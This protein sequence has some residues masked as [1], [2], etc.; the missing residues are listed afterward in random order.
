MS[1]SKSII[2]SKNSAVT[3]AELLTKEGITSIAP[4]AGLVYEIVKL[5]INHGKNYI[6]DRTEDRVDEFHQA[7]LRGKIS[8]EETQEFVQKE[9]N[10]DDYYAVLSACVQDIENEKVLIYSQLMSSLIETTLDSDVR[11]HFIKSCK[12]LSYSELC[13]L[14]D[15]YINS[16][17]DMMTVGGTHQQVKTMLTSA[18]PLRDL[19]IEKLITWG[20][21]DKEN[22]KITSL[23]E[24]LVSAI[25]LPETLHPEAIGRK[26]FSGIRVV[27]V[28]Y[29]LGDDMHSM[30]AKEIQNALWGN[31]IKSSIHVLDG[32]QSRSGYFYEAAVLIADGKKLEPKYIEALSQFAKNKPIFRINTERKSEGNEIGSIKFTAELT[33]SSMESL[34]I[35]KEVSRFISNII[36]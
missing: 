22:V 36:A 10:P 19:A 31:Q 20:Y 8:E 32:H 12:E 26:P 3:I 1:Q 5:M 29:Q 14:K 9:F 13:F 4:G 16:K 21:F 30:V 6:T 24:K 2:R 7:L 35:R 23:G 15:L 28:S 25:F 18:D 33:L 17:H 11:R 34:E 27:I